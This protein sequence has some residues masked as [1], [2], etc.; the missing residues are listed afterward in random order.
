MDSLNFKK[1]VT[2]LVVIAAFFSLLTLSYWQVQ[3]LEWKENIIAQLDEEYLK[4]PIE[5]VYNFEN[6]LNLEEKD[7]PILFGSILGR[8]TKEPIFL[9]PKVYEGIVGAHVLQP[10][11]IK[12][13]GT[14]IVNRGWIAHEKKELLSLKESKQQLVSGLFR[15]P[16]WNQFTSNNS[17]EQNI[18]TKPDIEEMA[19][20]FNIKKI[21]PVMLY[22]TQIEDNQELVLQ[23]QKWYPRNKHAQYAT[24]WFSMGFLLL[25]LVG[26]AAHRNKTS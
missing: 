10:F 14:I 13:G 19:N 23:D 12:T 6:L 9:E 8:F 21:A 3:R 18:W 2:A 7:L 20:H 1:A 24:F 26:V 5:F 17:P 22:A 11:A 16:D 15:K 25:I 4:E